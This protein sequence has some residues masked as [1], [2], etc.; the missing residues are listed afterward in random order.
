MTKRIYSF[1]KSAT[2]S[3]KNGGY[4]IAECAA[5][6]VFVIPV[7]FLLLFVVVEIVQAYMIDTVLAQTANKAA[8]QMAV[9]YPDNPGIATVRTTQDSMVYGAIQ[10]PSIVVDPG[11]FDD[12]V[13]NTNADPPTVTV[14]VHYKGGQYGLDPF[15]T[16]DPLGIGNSIQLY[17]T[18]VYKIEQD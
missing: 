18:A 13:F 16:W 3:R 14:T 15:P 4:F 7:V 1:N 10:Y 12:A 2:Q 17:G 9:L 5:S 8:R 6:L 11:Q